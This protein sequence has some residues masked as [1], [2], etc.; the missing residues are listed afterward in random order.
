MEFLLF[1]EKY[2]DLKNRYEQIST[3][4]DNSVIEKDINELKEKTLIEGFWDNKANASDILKQIS[5]KE[6]D[7]EFYNSVLVIHFCLCN[8]CICLC[9]AFFLTSSNRSTVGLLECSHFA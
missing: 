5:K 2:D 6:S 1:K 8:V 4:L 3:Y 7:L 9:H